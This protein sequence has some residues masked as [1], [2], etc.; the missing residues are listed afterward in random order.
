MHACMH[1]W[2]IKLAVSV[3]G[4]LSW[5]VMLFLCAKIDRMLELGGGVFLLSCYGGG[6]CQ[7]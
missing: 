6:G 5:L 2:E 1:A 4:F 3:F 7:V